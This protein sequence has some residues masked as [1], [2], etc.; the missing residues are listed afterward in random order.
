MSRNVYVYAYL[1]SKWWTEKI[2][3]E[4]KSV[5]LRD[6]NMVNSCLFLSFWKKSSAFSGDAFIFLAVPEIK[7]NKNKNK[8]F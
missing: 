2:T 6:T 7:Q 8:L 3:P 5:C 4:F 1:W